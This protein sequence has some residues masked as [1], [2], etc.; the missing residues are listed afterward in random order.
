M[1]PTAPVSAQRFPR[2]TACKGLDLLV[3]TQTQ[4]PVSLSLASLS[5]MLLSS[6][7]CL[8]FFSLILTFT[9]SGLSQL[10]LRMQIPHGENLK[11]KY[12]LNHTALPFAV[13][14]E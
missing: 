4:L 7:S 13:L 2:M 6:L 1:K 14:A 11:K 12:D 8:I 10:I 3:Q 9:D 5:R